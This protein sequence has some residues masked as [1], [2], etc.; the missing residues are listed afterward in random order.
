ML[1][2]GGCLKAAKTAEFSNHGPLRLSAAPPEHQAFGFR[3]F[4]F[5]KA[6]SSLPPSSPSVVHRMQWKIPNDARIPKTLH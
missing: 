3:A 5:E 1:R 6:R 4:H 2:W